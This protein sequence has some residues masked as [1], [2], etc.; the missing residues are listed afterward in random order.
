M[1]EVALN[2]LSHAETEQLIRVLLEPE[3]ENKGA[4]PTAV[5]TQSLLTRFSRWLFRET[6]G[7]PLFL[8]ETLK[9]LV[10][11]GLIQRER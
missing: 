3:A 8:M 7:Q 2:A 9:S 5:D 11:D 6:G 4:S 1:M 10:E